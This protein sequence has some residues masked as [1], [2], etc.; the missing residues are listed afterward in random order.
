MLAG[1]FTGRLA[2]EGEELALFKPD[3][4]QQPPHPDAGY[5]PMILVERVVYD[6]LLP[7]PAAAG[8][9]ASSS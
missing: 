1:P 4:P 2:N 3:A 9:G 8:H 7:W 5:V 6:E